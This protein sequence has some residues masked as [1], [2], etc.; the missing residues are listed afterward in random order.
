[1]GGWCGEVDM[2]GYVRVLLTY[3]AAVGLGTDSGASGLWVCSV[4][5]CLGSRRYEWGLG[6][7]WHEFPVSTER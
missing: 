7:P 4:V 5:R 3:P 1:M 6:I 2:V